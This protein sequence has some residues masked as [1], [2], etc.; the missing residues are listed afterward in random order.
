MSNKEFID[1]RQELD[2]IEYL[3]NL[4]NERMKRHEEAALEREARREF[5]RAQHERIMNAILK[6]ILTVL[7][8]IVVVSM[9]F[10]LAYKNVIA[11]WV[12]EKLAVGLALCGAFWLGYFW[13]ELKM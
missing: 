9:L 7:W 5:Q 1:E 8:Y 2:E 11:W 4:V 6:M 3:N 13:K 10:V 12:S